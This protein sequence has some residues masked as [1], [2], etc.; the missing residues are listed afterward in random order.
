M[1]RTEVRELAGGT[2]RVTEVHR[3]PKQV[4]HEGRLD[5]TLD[6]PTLGITVTIPIRDEESAV[7]A[8]L[9]GL[10]GHAIFDGGIGLSEAGALVHRLVLGLLALI[11]IIV[12]RER[13]VVHV[14]AHGLLAPRL[15]HYAN[16]ND[17]RA[18]REL[19]GLGL[20]TGGRPSASEGLGNIIGRK[21]ALLARPL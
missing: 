9:V 1:V 15:E 10:F 19:G 4:A 21:P 6:Q 8:V 16:S 18:R 12:I 13:A 5:K 11:V 2:G 3:R 20:A 17:L 14:R 7:A